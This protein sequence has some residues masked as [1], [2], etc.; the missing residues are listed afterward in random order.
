[1]NTAMQKINLKEFA[2]SKNVTVR[3]ITEGTGI[4]ES[5]V[6][7]MYNTGEFDGNDIKINDILEIMDFLGIEKVSSLVPRIK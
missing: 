2:D 5:I 3:Q 4:S 6:N 7:S 1:M